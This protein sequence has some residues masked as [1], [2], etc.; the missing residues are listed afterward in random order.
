VALSLLGYLPP[1]LG[2]LLG[3]LSAALRGELRGSRVAA[4]FRELDGGG[5]FP[6]GLA[7]FD[8]AGGDIDDQLPELD[9]VA[10]TLQAVR[11]H[12]GN[13]ACLLATANPPSRDGHA[14]LR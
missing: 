5:F 10:R 8:L 12:V 9:R 1:S 13:M 3:D 6:I 11:T 4:L 14:L 2:S 7:V